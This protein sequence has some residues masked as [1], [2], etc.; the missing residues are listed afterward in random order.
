MLAPM[1]APAFASAFATPALSGFFPA[2]SAVSGVT[3]GM[4]K[5]DSDAPAQS[6][7]EYMASCAAKNAKGPAPPYSRVLGGGCF[8]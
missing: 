6:F 5:G 2:R 3:V 7:A 8:V 1:S 4:L